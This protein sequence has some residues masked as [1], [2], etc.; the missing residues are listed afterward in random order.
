MQIDEAGHHHA[1]GSI[2]NPVGR[3]GVILAD[4]GDGIAVE[5]D[6]TPSM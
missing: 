4:V 5:G 3:A 2:D 1:L 6:P